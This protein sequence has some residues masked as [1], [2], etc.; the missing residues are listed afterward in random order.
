[1]TDKELAKAP[2]VCLMGPTASGKSS[3]AMLLASRYPIE[4]VSVDSALVYRGMDI[5]TAK[6]SAFERALVPH[7]LIDITE[8]EDSYSAARFA[9][10]ASELIKEVRARRRVPL[11]VGGT[12]LYFRALQQGLDAMPGADAA[13]RA[14][15]EQEAVRLGWPALHQRLREVDAATAARLAPQD[16]QRISR[17]LEVYRISG[18]PLSQWHA[19]RAPID[20]GNFINL[21]LMPSERR[22]LHLRIEAR[23]DQMLKNGFLDE[24]RS[25]MARPGFHRDASSMRAVGYRQ[26][27][28]YLLGEVSAG[29]MRDRALAATRQLAKHQ[30]TWLRSMQKEQVVDCLA[31]D[32]ADQLLDAAA[33][34]LSAAA[35]TPQASHQ[36]QA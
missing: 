19:K 5:G 26:A 34:Y 29:E 10:D 18:T 13:I 14:E 33:N 21:A 3:L 12:M 22:P 8:P 2:T 15:L 17:A 16:A 4:I 9:S 32:A 7:H 27:I 35:D 20:S 24:V 23:Y 1:V 30:I 31:D 36:V 6:P 25:L 11:L 28:E